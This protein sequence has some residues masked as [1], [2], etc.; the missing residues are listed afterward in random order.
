VSSTD[1]IY[2]RHLARAIRDINTLGDEIGS[3]TRMPHPAITPVLGSGHPLADILLIK[4]RPQASEIAEGVA[5]FGRSG[6]AVL[7]SIRRL[8]IDPLAVY[9]TNCVKCSDG[10]PDAAAAACPAWLLREIAITEPKM[11]VVMGD[12]A[13]EAVNDLGVPLARA[14]DPGRV[15]SVQRFTPTIEAIVVPDIDGSLNDDASKR[16]FWDAFK[17]LG[18]WW[19]ALPP[20]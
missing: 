7:K 15:G 5:F 2:E 11:L 13:V 19:D 12:E 4:F 20:W 18:V 6:T 14:L 8:G 3:C 10:D 16:R 17:A 9:G 1:E